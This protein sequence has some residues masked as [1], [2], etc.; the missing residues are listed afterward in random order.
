MRALRVPVSISTCAKEL[1]RAI[2]S[3]TLPQVQA[4]IE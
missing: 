2:A 3:A 1:G 4:E